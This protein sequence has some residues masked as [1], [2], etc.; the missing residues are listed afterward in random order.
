[1]RDGV[2]AHQGTFEDITSDDPELLASWRQAL[3]DISESEAEVSVS[4][5]DN[6][7][8]RQTTRVTVTAGSVTGQTFV[9]GDKN[10]GKKGNRAY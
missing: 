1:M 8:R 2:I 6:P 10:K 7:D 4:D 5:S 9:G 3:V